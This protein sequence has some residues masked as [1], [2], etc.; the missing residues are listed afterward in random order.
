MDSPEDPQRTTE[1]ASTTIPF[2]Q[3]QANQLGAHRGSFLSAALNPWRRRVRRSTL[4]LNSPVG[5]TLFDF[6]A[7]T[8][9]SAPRKPAGPLTR[10]YIVDSETSPSG[11]LPMKPLNSLAQASRAARQIEREIAAQVTRKLHVAPAES[12]V[13]TIPV[14]YPPQPADPRLSARRF[15]Q[16][17]FSRT[18]TA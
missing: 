12:S 18:N 3:P 11:V 17:L 6:P 10:P 15:L 7:A 5:L 4:D 9:H 1:M 14:A 8:P 16:S 2:P 13:R